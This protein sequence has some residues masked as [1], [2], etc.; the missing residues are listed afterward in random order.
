[1]SRISS[2]F[3]IHVG[4]GKCGSTALQKFLATNNEG[5][6]GNGYHYPNPIDNSINHRILAIWLIDQ[7]KPLPSGSRIAAFPQMDVS[8]IKGKLTPIEHLQL[9]IQDSSKTTILSSESIYGID[10]VF[11]AKYFSQGNS[12]IVVYVREQLDYLLSAYAQVIQAKKVNQ[13]FAEFLNRNWSL[14]YSALI[15]AW[16]NAFGSDNVIPRIY[17]RDLLVEGDICKDFLGL[18][19]ITELNAFFFPSIVESNPSIGGPLLKFKLLL[20]S[21]SEWDEGQL[22]QKTYRG[23]QACAAQEQRYRTKLTVRKE[24][25]EKVRHRYRESNKEFFENH[26]PQLEGFSHKERHGSA[27]EEAR[28]TVEDFEYIC[29]FLCEYY[30]QDDMEQEKNDVIDIHYKKMKSLL[31]VQSF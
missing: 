12:K 15:K 13:S 6:Q 17:D 1:M 18:L 26:F 4:Q 11:L 3:I 2:P 19:S 30:Q 20:N 9:Q 8:H 22:M 23:L 27:P 14:D 21:V 31:T 10:P 7:W 28:L 29:M 24:L 25:A 16:I 5:L